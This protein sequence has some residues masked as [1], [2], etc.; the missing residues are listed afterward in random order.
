MPDI[1]TADW[2][3]IDAA[4]DRFER[5]CSRGRRPRIEDHLHDVSP[6]RVSAI[7]DELIRVEC[8]L[9]R[10]GGEEPTAEE[11][12]ARFPDHIGVVDAVFGANL[13][14]PA[15]AGVDDPRRENQTP[16]GQKEPR[17]ESRPYHSTVPDEPTPGQPR[18]STANGAG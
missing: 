8:E 11:Y 13:P 7:L 3:W 12:R 1:P 10:R 18:R 2:S 16:N 6:D 9:R 4:A 14:E 17:E 5:A 15:N